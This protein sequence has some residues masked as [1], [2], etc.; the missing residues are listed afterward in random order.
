MLTTQ[1]H[2]QDE[3]DDHGTRISMMGQVCRTTQYDDYP[4]WWPSSVMTTQYYDQDKYDGTKLIAQLDDL[5]H[6]YLDFCDDHLVG[7]GN[8]I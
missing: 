5:C 2:D 6:C 3:Y 7:G 4:V 8:P 1:Y